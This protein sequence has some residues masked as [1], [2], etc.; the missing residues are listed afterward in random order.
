M[1]KLELKLNELSV[2]SFVLEMEKPQEKQIR[3]GYTGP[4]F[5]Q[6]KTGAEW[7]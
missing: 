6:W 7:C 1:K 2:R 5:C 3:G 4:Q